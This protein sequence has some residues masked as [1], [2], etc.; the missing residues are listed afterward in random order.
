MPPKDIGQI[1]IKHFIIITGSKSKLVILLLNKKL[2]LKKKMNKS[3][4]WKKLSANKKPRWKSF[5]KALAELN[6]VDKIR[7][8]NQLKLDYTVTE[9]C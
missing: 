5:K 4:R 2:S 6:T 9:L 7:I 3:K 1:A 8:I